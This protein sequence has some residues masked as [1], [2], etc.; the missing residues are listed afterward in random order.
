MAVDGRYERKIEWH[1]M[2]K[3]ARIP[4]FVTCLQSDQPEASLIKG[5]CFLIQ[6]TH[7]PLLS[8]GC[9]LL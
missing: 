5:K 7:A 6:I 3:R 2:K 4:K 9:I 8:L 1:S